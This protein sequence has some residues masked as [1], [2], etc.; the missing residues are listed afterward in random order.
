LSSQDHKIS[1]LNELRSA[2]ITPILDITNTCAIHKDEEVKFYCFDHEQPCCTVCGGM[3]HRK[4]DHFETFENAAQIVRDTGRV[5][6]ILGDVNELRSKLIIA[7]HEA[8]TNLTEIEDSVDK[9]K[10]KLEEDLKTLVD[11]LQKVQQK[12]MEEISIFFKKSRGKL[13]ACTDILSDGIQYAEYCSKMLEQ[14]R[15]S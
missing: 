7:R 4:C 5:G 13:K 9:V 15:I 3:E 14:A 1:P 6:S 8:D 2:K 10:A 12:H 11:H